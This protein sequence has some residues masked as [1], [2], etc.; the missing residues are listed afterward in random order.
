MLTFDGNV[1][2]DHNSW[3]GGFFLTIEVLVLILCYVRFIGACQSARLC[4]TVFV[5]R[6]VC[7][8][9]YL[10]VSGVEE[11]ALFVLTSYWHQAHS[12]PDQGHWMT[13]RSQEPSLSSM[14]RHCSEAKSQIKP[15]LNHQIVPFR[16]KLEYSDS[17]AS[18][19]SLLRLYFCFNVNCPILIDADQ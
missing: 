5:S 8:Y 15:Q 2:S 9:L 11:G 6:P 10:S 3:N 14:Y 12:V 13:H 17:Y 1:E 7:W 16:Q 4:G 19:L 18:S